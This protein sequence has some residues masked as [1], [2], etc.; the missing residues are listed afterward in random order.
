MYS[1]LV[2]ATFTLYVNHHPCMF[3]QTLACFQTEAQYSLTITLPPGNGPSTFSLCEF[4]DFMYLTSYKWNHR[5]IAFCDWF[6]SLSSVISRSSV[7]KLIC[8]QDCCFTFSTVW[9]VVL[10]RWRQ[11]MEE[12]LITKVTSLLHTLSFKCSKDTWEYWGSPELRGEVGTVDLKSTV[13][14]VQAAFKTT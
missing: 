4:Y 9:M 12:R 3:P 8:F 2:S 10:L 7:L 1:S 11:P 13:I 14:K 5:I 6:I